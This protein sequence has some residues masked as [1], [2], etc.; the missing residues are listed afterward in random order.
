MTLCTGFRDEGKIHG[1]ALK[2]KSQW[3]RD[4]VQIALVWFCVPF[5]FD[6]HRVPPEVTHVV[7]IEESRFLAKVHGGKGK[8]WRL[9][10]QVKRALVDATDEK[11]IEVYGFPSHRHLDNAVEFLQRECLRYQHSPPDHRAD[12]QKLYL[13]LQEPDR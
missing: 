1:D 7:F 6:N 9:N 12:V 11:P 2:L 10:V 8:S 3:H 13:E 5:A 4:S